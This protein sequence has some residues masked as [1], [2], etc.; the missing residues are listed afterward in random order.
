VFQKC[1]ILIKK[2]KGHKEIDYYSFSGLL[3]KTAKNEEKEALTHDKTG[4]KFL[5]SKQSHRSKELHPH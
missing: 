3:E 1:P 4:R 2:E 5:F